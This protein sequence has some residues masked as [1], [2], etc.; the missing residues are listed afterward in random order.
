AEKLLAANQPSKAIE[1]LT[2][3]DKQHPGHAAISLR[4]GEIYDTQ[5]NTGY[6]LFYY[7]RYLHMVEGAPREHAV[8]RIN[9][10]EM[11]AGAPQEAEAAARALGE[12]TRAVPT[13]APRIEKILAG[14][15]EDGTLIP[16]HNEEELKNIGKLAQD[17][18]RRAAAVTPSVTPIVIP[19]ALLAETQQKVQQAAAQ[20]EPGTLQGARSQPAGAKPSVPVM[21]RRTPPPDEDA[22]LAQAFLSTDTATE[23]APK[24]DADAAADAAQPDGETAAPVSSLEQELAMSVATPDD[25]SERPAPVSR[26]ADLAPMGEIAAPPSLSA[27]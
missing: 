8:A 7:R 1:V 20:G 26:Q 16:I 9:T 10:L 6:A 4:L 5:N 23:D 27:G 13:P 2:A 19:E 17:A 14:A 3:L 22:L 12:Q 15:T 18:S 11:T 24:D 25:E 21:P